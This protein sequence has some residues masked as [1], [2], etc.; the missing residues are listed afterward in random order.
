MPW[1]NEGVPTD[2]A[3]T[4][5]SPEVITAFTML[6]L[7]DVRARILHQLHQHPA[8]ATTG[9]LAHELGIPQPTIIRHIRILE[10]VGAVVSDTEVR[11]GARVRYRVDIRTLAVLLDELRLYVMPPVR[12]RRNTP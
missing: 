11:T 3:S 12:S 8:G 9:F 2:A 1:E 10:G 5:P 4:S 7:S 6:G